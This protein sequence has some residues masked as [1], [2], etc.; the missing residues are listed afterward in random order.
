[1]FG[2]IVNNGTL[3]LAEIWQQTRYS[4]EKIFDRSVSKE[5]PF[6]SQMILSDADNHDKSSLTYKK[7]KVG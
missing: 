4:F 5:K 3:A 7:S 2:S 1:M 6:S